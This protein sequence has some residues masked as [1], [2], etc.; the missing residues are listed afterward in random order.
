MKMNQ[1]ATIFNDILSLIYPK[2]C[3]GC[4]EIL[5]VTSKENFC[6]NCLPQFKIKEV[7]RCKICGRII[8]H[9]GNCRACNSNNFYFAKGYSVFEYKGAVRDSIRI[10]KYRGLFSNGKVI[11]KIMADY[12]IDNIKLEY[13]YV[14]AVPLHPKRYRSRGYNQSEILAKIVAKA[15]NIKYCRLLERHI[16]TNPQNSL[17]KKE[18]LENIKGAFRLKNGVNVENKKILIIDDIFT[19]GSTI[20][21]CCK[22]LKK[23]N[24]LF[25]DFFTFS[26]LGED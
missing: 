9:N 12:A 6:N 16:N 11:G 13:D 22:V 20:N 14:T 3:I 24:A 21:E 17:N 4:N 7:R 23:N 10:F 18:R 8:Y 5:N 2:R 19:T 26:C 25:V 15:M 1:L